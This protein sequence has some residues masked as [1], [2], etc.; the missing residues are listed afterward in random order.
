MGFFSWLTSDTG[1]SIAN[2]A[3]SRRTFPCYVICPDD[4]LIKET[5]YEGYGI[6]GGHDIY[7]LLAKW[8][9]PDEC[10]GNEEVDRSIGID[11]QYNRCK[12]LQFPIK[13]VEFDKY[14]YND[15][16]ASLECPDQG[17]FYGEDFEEDEEDVKI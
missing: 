3:S 11:I 7:A 1:K 6:F 14:G 5:D 15:V 8:N 10:I 17:Y 13:I 16:D 4:S 2:S 9:A 12:K